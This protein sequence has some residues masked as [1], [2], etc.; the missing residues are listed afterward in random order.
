MMEVAGI[1]GVVF[2]EVVSFDRSQTRGVV[3]LLNGVCYLLSG[4]RGWIGPRGVHGSGWVV[5]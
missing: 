3:G 1:H 2:G 5:V 4:L